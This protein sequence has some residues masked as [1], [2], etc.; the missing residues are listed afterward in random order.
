MGR[1]NPKIYD[2]N[3]IFQFGKY[4]GYTLEE[5]I[6]DDGFN[7]HNYIM[8][9]IRERVLGF[10][11]EAIEGINKYSALNHLNN[12][13]EKTDNSPV[14]HGKT[15]VVIE[16]IN[17]YTCKGELNEDYRDYIGIKKIQAMKSNE[18]KDKGFGDW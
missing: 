5:I 1:N 10:T 11:K 16:D 2:W 9:C 15:L 7:G 4:K 13:F 17:E 12:S 3:C 18:I 14:L 6:K 8:W